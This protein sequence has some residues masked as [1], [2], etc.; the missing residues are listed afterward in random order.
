MEHKYESD[1]TKKEKRQMELEKLKGMT[2]LQKLD[3]IWTYYKIL[4]VIPLILAG[5]V[6]MGVTM[7]QNSLKNQVLSVTVVGGE[8]MTTEDIEALE[9]EIRT[10]LK[11]EGKH[12]T[13]LIQPNISTNQSDPSA[14]MS[15]VTLVAAQ[16]VDVLVCPEEIYEDYKKQNAFEGSVMV[17]RNEGVIQEKFSVRYDKVYVGVMANS[18]QKENAKTFA[19]YIKN[20]AGQE[21]ETAE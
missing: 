16:A 15:L 2:F 1:M 6:Y 20:N 11:A 3:Y 19:E 8:A 14:N 21:S 9:K 13:V 7:Y 10:C 4:F 17:Y 5:V 18:V 12:D